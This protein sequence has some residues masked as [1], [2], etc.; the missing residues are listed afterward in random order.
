MPSRVVPDITHPSFFA[1]QVGVNS[2][3]G[4]NS[5]Q[6]IRL[7]I[8]WEELRFRNSKSIQRHE[9]GVKMAIAFPLLSNMD[10]DVSSPARER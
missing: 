5:R 3:E 1:W 2:S 8:V 4:F 6:V 9:L 10:E 7:V